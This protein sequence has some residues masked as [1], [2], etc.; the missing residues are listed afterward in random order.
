MNSL[1]VVV[2]AV[3]SVV[4]VS[5][6]LG[7]QSAARRPVVVKKVNDDDAALDELGK[8]QLSRTEQF[9]GEAG[10]A[11]LR[12]AH[13][14]VIGLGGVGSHAAHMLARSG[15]GKLRLVDFDRVTLSSLNRHALAVRADVGMWKANVLVD[16]I[17]LIVGKLCEMEPVVALCSKDNVYELI[18]GTD[19]V[20]DCIDDQTTKI[21]LLEACQKRNIKVLSSMG[22]GGKIDPTRLRIGKMSDSN[23]DPLAA[24]LRGRI[25]NEKREVDLEQIEVV[26]SCEEPKAGLLKLSASQAENPDEFGALPHFRVRIMPVLGTSPAL[27]G[28]AIAARVLTLVA[29]S[30]HFTPMAVDVLSKNLSHGFVQR[31]RNHEI[32]VFGKGPDRLTEEDTMY[33]AVRARK[34][35]LFTHTK[36]GATDGKMELARWFPHQPLDV[37][38]CIMAQ[39][40][41]VDRIYA[42]H[43]LHTGLPPTCDAL[44]CTPQDIARVE[45]WLAEEKTMEYGL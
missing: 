34:R 39:K 14:T 22:A 26:Y 45:L 7:R 41:I 29:E 19:F 12:G 32:K 15:V 43:A 16:R 23:W 42:H 6:W 35:C 21:E 36:M 24:R 10:L 4:V 5:F 1:P 20:I 3:S 30:A 2:L 40:P 11:K 17:Q 33:V 9:L 31:I 18:A 8:E 25:V 27:F 38:N 28:V 37:H 13:V 44:G